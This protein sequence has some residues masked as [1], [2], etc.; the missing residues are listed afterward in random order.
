MVHEVSHV[1]E[2]INDSAH[3]V[4]IQAHDDAA[5]SLFLALI[6]SDI[7][8][9]MPLHSARRQQN[10]LHLEKSRQGVFYKMEV[11]V[12]QR[13]RSPTRAHHVAST[14]KACPGATA[15][16]GTRATKRPRQGFATFRLKHTPLPNLHESFI[17]PQSAFHLITVGRVEIARITSHQEYFEGPGK[18]ARVQMSRPCHHPPNHQQR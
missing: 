6:A 14:P 3:F 16:H 2:K 5:S 8:S 11:S 13:R 18:T 7:T 12:L 15:R 10:A 17:H 4:I 9:N 1:R